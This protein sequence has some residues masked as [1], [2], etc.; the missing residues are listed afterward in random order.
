[1]TDYRPAS[2][3][4]RIATKLIADHHIDLCDVRIEYVFRDEAAKKNGKVVFGTARK[5]SGLNAFLATGEVDEAGIQHGDADFYVIEIAEDEW[6]E[7]T[8]AQRIALVDHELC[9]C[10]VEWDDDG[11][12]TLKMRP[13]DLEEFREIVDRHGLWEPGVTHMAAAMARAQLAGEET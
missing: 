9:H 11:A 5:V 12:P 3:V 6:Q 4:A 8:Q 13:H 2:E 10:Q 1:M 7:L